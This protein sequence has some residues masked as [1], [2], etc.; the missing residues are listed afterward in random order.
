MTY[1]LLSASKDAYLQDKIIAGKRASTSNTGQAGTL[2]AYKLYNESTLS[3]SSG[4]VVELSRLLL[5]FDYPEDFLTIERVSH[6]SF[7]ASLRLKDV[8]GGQTVPSNYDLVAYPLA[9]AFDEGRGFDV[10]AYRDLDTANFESASYGVAWSLSG[11]SAQ[12]N[13]GDS[14]IDIFVSGDLGFGSESLGIVQ[15]FERG[16]EDAFF[17]V[18][19]LVSASI[20]GIVDNNGFRISFIDSQE[21]DG[22]T[23]FV[24]R[25]GS[26]QAMNSTLRPRLVVEFDD[27]RLADTSGD[28]RFSLSQSFFVYNQVQGNLINFVSG[29]AD[30][31]GANC[32]ELEF[33][34]SKSIEFMTSSFQPNFSASINHLTRSVVYYSQSFSGSLLD[35]G[36]YYS[37]F[38]L[39][40]TTDSELNNFIA[41]RNEVELKGTWKNASGLVTLATNYFK[42]KK[43]LGGYNNSFEK[44]YVVNA[45]NLKQSYKKEEQA[46]IRVFAQDRDL[47]QVATR[48]PV[49]TRPLIVPDMRWRLIKA[50][51]K[52][53]EVIPFSINTRLSTDSDGMYFDLFPCDLDINEVYELEFII[54]NDQG[55]DFVVNNKGFIFKVT[56]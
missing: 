27:D 41:N 40:P 49:P 24:K 8:Y 50:Y 56:K 42:F 25:F 20:V 37:N 38:I 39:D 23:R 31:T 13:I 54:K 52:H 4:P 5:K 3:G 35:M 48:Y 28:P 33:A 45:T 44:N 15:Q 55:K 29:G 1:R 43:L 32:V 6:P 17:N 22:I 47:S 2:D 9:K 10:V 14:N 11:A 30:I 36:I 51:S 53:E 7:T 26:R 34:A 16:D 46:R 19:K 12:G 18:T 21:Q